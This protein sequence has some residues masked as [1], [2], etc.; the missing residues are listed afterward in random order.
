MGHSE[1]RRVATRLNHGKGK[2]E[3]EGEAEE[4]EEREG[5]P[6]DEAEE[7]V[8]REGTDSVIMLFGEL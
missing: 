5:H 6:A 2:G 3:G 4:E 7:V 8:V 1:S